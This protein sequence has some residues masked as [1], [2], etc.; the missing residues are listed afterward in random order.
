VHPDHRGGGAVIKHLLAAMRPEVER[1]GYGGAWT[2]AATPEVA[3][4]LDTLGAKLYQAACYFWP[5][6]RSTSATLS[7]D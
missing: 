5:V 3:K 2:G 7:K 1:A 4:M 6:A